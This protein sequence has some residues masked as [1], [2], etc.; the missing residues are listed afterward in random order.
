MRWRISYK[1]VDADT[2]QIMF[3]I[4]KEFV[5][6]GYDG[7]TFQMEQASFPKSL[8]DIFQ[9][10]KDVGTGKLMVDVLLRVA[11]FMEKV[12]REER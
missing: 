3:L 8:G 4:L 5:F 2:N 9:A 7:I 1:V 12:L 11:F 10:G 6:L